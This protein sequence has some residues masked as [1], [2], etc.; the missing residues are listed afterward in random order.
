MY[1]IFPW[2]NPQVFLGI[3]IAM[4]DTVLNEAI[5]TNETTG[6]AQIT[7]LNTDCKSFFVVING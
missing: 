2:F 1:D 5:T 7:D 3:K 4:K 6:V